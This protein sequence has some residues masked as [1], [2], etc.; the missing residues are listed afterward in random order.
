MESIGKIIGERI[1]PAAT[2]VGVIGGGAWLA[3]AGK[4]GQSAQNWFGR[5]VV[6]A[7]HI[8]SAAAFGAIGYTVI[9]AA[10]SCSKKMEENT[11][12]RHGIAIVATVILAGG[13]AYGAATAGFIGMAALPVIVGVVAAAIAVHLIVKAIIG[14]FMDDKPAKAALE[15]AITDAKAAVAAAEAALAP[16]SKP[17]DAA[18]KAVRDAV[19]AAKTKL[20]AEEEKFGKLQDKAKLEKAVADTQT[21]WDTA[22]ATRAPL[23]AKVKE[24]EDQQTAQKAL[25]VA[26]TAAGKKGGDKEFDDPTNALGKIANDLPLAKNAANAVDVAAAEQA[27]KAA[28]KDLNDAKKDVLAAK[29]AVDTAEAALKTASELPDNKKLLDAE[30][31]LKTKVDE[32]KKAQAD[33]EAKLVEHYPPAET[34]TT[35]TTAAPAAATAPVATPAKP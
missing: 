20:A 15:K 29:A 8:A 19:A 1:V 9:E 2:A 31:I 11:Y 23:D 32:A 13:A 14:L 21:A 12:L 33:A 6:P 16:A 22:K 7:T 26:A 3:G 34:K 35:A 30:A 4:L 18:L 10:L 28:E 5:L 17:V 24:L 27:F 25:L